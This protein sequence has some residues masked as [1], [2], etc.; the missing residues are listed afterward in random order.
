MDNREQFFTDV[1]AGDLTGVRNWLSFDRKLSRRM[2]DGKLAI[3]VAAMK[4]HTQVVKE[5]LNY[6]PNINQRDDMG[7]SS[8]HY[9]VCSGT[10]ELV[11]LFSDSDI[12]F[13]ARNAF[14]QTPMHL[15]S[16]IN[17]LKFLLSQG[18]DINILD[19][20]HHTIMYG[21][22]EEFKVII[23]THA[24]KLAYIN[25]QF[26]LPLYNELLD[27]SAIAADP[28]I[29]YSELNEEIKKMQ[30]VIVD[31]VKKLTMLNMLEMSITDM[32]F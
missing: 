3:H 23:R 1:C 9:A 4:G 16:D 31:D 27:N 17:I 19:K 12:N 22:T 14:G 6:C 24:V 29:I 25:Q 28:I 21:K 15:C 32:V 5:L 2:L 26:N 10:M 11:E 18:A 8:L 7:N 30:K 20:A 13:D